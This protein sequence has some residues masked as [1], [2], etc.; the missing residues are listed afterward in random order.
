MS[1]SHSQQPQY[2]FIYKTILHAYL[3][4]QTELK[5]E[6]LQDHIEKLQQA[7]PNSEDSHLDKEFMVSIPL[8]LLTLFPPPS[9][10]HS[11]GAASSVPE[12]EEGDQSA[13]LSYKNMDK[14]RNKHFLPRMF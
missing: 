5:Y 2:I 6:D 1:L 11:Q 4:G 7:F 13:A 14:N 8:H 10:S 3:Y 9:L 12:L